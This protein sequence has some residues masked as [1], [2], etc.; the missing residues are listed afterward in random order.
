MLAAMQTIV[1]VAM[2]VLSVI[3]ALFIG[4]FL[5]PYLKKKG[6][7]L[8]THEDISK[9]V[10]QVKAV[11]RTTEEIKSEISSGLWD[12]QRRWDMKR[13]VVFDAAK[14]LSEVEDALL[15]VSIVLKEDHAK[16][17]KWETEKP[18]QEEELAWSQ[19]RNERMTRWSKAST[20]F[21]E[22]R[23]FVRIVCGKEAALVFSELGSFI[24]KLVEEMTKDPER[25]DSA[26]PELL[27]K[28]LEAQKA[29][30]TELEVEAKPQST[31]S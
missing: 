11:T 26:R 30:R 3:A 6:E 7:N 18:L 5:K 29:M 22:S 25:Y 24:H 20:D 2:W 28:I 1:I 19:V 12:R 10:D 23:A 14:R 4:S 21:D 27:K 16:K 17:K 8:A 31:G 9:L 15:G 13:E